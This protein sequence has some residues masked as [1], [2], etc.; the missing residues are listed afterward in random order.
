LGLDLRLQNFEEELAFL[1]GKYALP[2]GRL[3]IAIFNDNLAGYI[4]LRAIDKEYCEMKRLYVRAQF[5]KLGI[6]YAL[7]KKVID[8]AKNI[9]YV[10][11]LLDT[12]SSMQDAISLYRTID[13]INVE[14][15]YNN[16][17]DNIVYLGLDL[18]NK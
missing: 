15:Y 4:A 1:S 3:Y 7:A 10:C 13:F 18:N 2:Y 16:P 17:N 6:G 11:M 9:G 12:S 8:D 5:R 14:P